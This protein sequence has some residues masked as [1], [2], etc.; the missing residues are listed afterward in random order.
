MPDAT[1][2]SREELLD[3]ATADALG[4]IDEVDAARF[5]RAFSA[6]SPSL[7]AEVRGLQDRVCSDRMLLSDEQPAASLRLKTLARVAGEI[8]AQAALAAPIATIGPVRQP[9]ARAAHSLDRD[10]LVREI[11]ERSAL[12]RR[13]TQH[14]WR[15]AALFLFAA[16]AV[17]LYFHTQQRAISERLMD[18]VDRKL[19]DDAMHAVAR[20]TA[21]F[22]FAGA[23]ELAVLDSAGA[24]SKLVHAY[25]DESTGRVCVVG[26]GIDATGKPVRV[27]SGSTEVTLVSSVVEDRGFAVIFDPPGQGTA[28]SGATLSALTPGALRLE[29]AGSALT[30]VA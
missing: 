18:L 5:E 22:D 16:L 28:A 26:F 6:A 10:A 4:V 11:L 9:H 20:S 12:E 23:R 14:I 13:P 2:I 1:N 7:Q 25:L 21:G 15:A 3:L 8:E 19:V 27:S 24:P 30:I 17:A 29:I